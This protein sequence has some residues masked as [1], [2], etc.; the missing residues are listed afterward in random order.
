MKNKLTEIRLKEELKK[1]IDDFDD[2]FDEIEK[3]VEKK[4][5]KRL[6]DLE[7]DFIE[8]DNVFSEKFVNLMIFLN[9]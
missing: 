2:I 6:I 8:I 4:D 3:V 9:P 1:A 5:Y 7:H